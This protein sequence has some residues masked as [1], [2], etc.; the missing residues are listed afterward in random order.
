M[1]A[2]DLLRTIEKALPELRRLAVAGDLDDYEDDLDRAAELLV[3][4]VEAFQD[5]EKEEIE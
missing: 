3:A 2:L 5:D 4:V 1:N